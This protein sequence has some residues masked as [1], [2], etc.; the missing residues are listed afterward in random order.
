MEMDDTDVAK[1]GCPGDQ[2][3]SSTDGVAAAH[4]R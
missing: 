2:A 3:S 4:C 1:L